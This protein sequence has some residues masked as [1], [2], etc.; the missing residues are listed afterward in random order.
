MLILLVRKSS[1][2]Q[3]KRIRGGFP[4]AG[5]PREDS[6]KLLLFARFLTIY[7]SYVFKFARPGRGT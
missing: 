5:G 1:G 3:T 4:G 2:F 7:D 6:K